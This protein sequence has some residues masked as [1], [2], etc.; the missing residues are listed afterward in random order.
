MAIELP[1]KQAVIVGVGWAGGIVAA[2]LA[3]AGIEVL[4]LERGADRTPADFIMQK[5]EMKYALDHDLMQDLSKETV[6]FRND[7][8]MTALPMRQTGSFVL[9][10]DLGGAG[11]HWNGQAP[12]FFPYDF[13]IRTHTIDRYGE[14]KIEEGI[15][16]QD[17]GITYD[18]LEPYYT[19]WEKTAG[20][21][22]EQNDMTPWMSEEYPTPPMKE[23][24]AIRLFKDAASDLGLHPH[25]RP[26]A[27]LSENYTNP[28]GKTI[29]QCQ[30]CS[31]C[32]RFGCDYQAKSDPLITVI[33]TAVD[34]G[35]FEIKTHA[36][37]RE[38]EHEDGKAV[39]VYYIDGND[40][41]QYYQPADMVIL[42]TYVLNNTRLMLQ[43]GIGQPYDPETEEGVV[44]KHYCYQIMSGAQGMFEDKQFN[45]Y[46]G[47]GALGGGVEDYNG[48]NFDHSDL[49]FIH[50]G[51]LSLNQTGIRPIETNPVPPDTKSWGSEFKKA[52]THYFYRTLSIGSQGASMPYRYNY[53]DLD[54]TYTD[55]NG[56]PLL[57][58]TYNFT[59]QDR[60][61]AAHQAERSEE[62]MK[63]MGADIVT[64]TNQATGD[65]NIVPYQ[66]THNTGGTIMGASSETSVVNNYSQ[67]W[68]CENLFVVGASTF[69]HNGGNNP[70]PTV[71]ALAYRAAEGMLEYFEN[72]GILV[73][74]ED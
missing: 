4:G 33:P 32:E 68:D 19:K 55:E 24:P 61:L 11:I 20:I 47:A 34:T 73:E 22:G 57:R 21:S 2:E 67:V 45:L 30:F 8:D 54:P 41:Q 65:Y 23:T 69:T 3:K 39:G 53:L 36:N 13:E 37:V 72:P 71:G 35:N 26:S 66:T 58:M 38:V 7:K 1:K 18:E 49:D 42:T 70:T 5:D 6:S 44:G 29:Y 25:Q 9:G 14:D 27:N 15:T 60:K 50:G 17:W 74:D 52:S 62:I 63:Q 51:V 40:G 31:F 12:R 43:S 59:D 46:A 28:D 48:D 56:D 10:T 64:Q 16:L